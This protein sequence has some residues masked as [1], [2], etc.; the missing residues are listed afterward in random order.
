MRKSQHFKS[1]LNRIIL[2]V[3]LTF[4]FFLLYAQ[5]NPT[6]WL[7]PIPKQ[8]GFSPSF[9]YYV[10]KD[11]KGFVWISSYE[12]LNRYDGHQ[13]KLYRAVKEDVH[14]LRNNN[15]YGH[16]FEDSKSNIWFSTSK[17]IHRY[18]RK[19]DSFD[20]FFL[21]HDST[22]TL[23]TD[24]H[25]FAF[26]NDRMLWVQT[27]SG[28][29]KYD[30]HTQVDTL[31][32]DSTL[33]YVRPAYNPQGQVTKI[34]S[35]G[36]NK[37]LLEID[38]RDQNI[39]Q[40]SN[41]LFTN[42]EISEIYYQNDSLVF[43][44]SSENGIQR[45]NPKTDQRVSIGNFT[46]GR[47]S[48]CALDDDHILMAIQKY[49]LFRYHFKDDY[50]EKINTRFISG[51]GE[52]ING[53]WK[54]YKDSDENI[55]VSDE[56]S[57][58]TVGNLKKNKFCSIPKF[59]STTANSNFSYRKMLEDS[60]GKIWIA[61]QGAGLF[62][63]DPESGETQNFSYEKNMT[64]AIPSNMVLD[65]CEDA[66]GKIWVATKEGIAYFLGGKRFRKVPV[67]TTSAQ[68]IPY[69]LSFLKIDEQ[70]ILAS[71]KDGI[72]H[73]IKKG[74]NYQLKKLYA[75]DTDGNQLYQDKK[76]NII[77]ACLNADL[78][79]FKWRKE[80]LNF[81]YQVPFNTHVNAFWENQFDEVLWCAT[82]DGLFKISHSDQKYQKPEYIAFQ[83]QSKVYSIKSILANEPHS[84]WMGTN[85]GLL[86]VKKDSFTVESFSMADG[87]QSLEFNDES[88]L[89]RENGELW[90]GGFNGI[91][92]VPN[93]KITRTNF[94]PQLKITDIK[95]NDSPVEDLVCSEA[96]A[97]NITE[98][99]HLQRSFG[100]NTI[101]LSFVGMDYSDPKST[102]LEFQLTGSDKNPVRLAKG[103]LG[104]VR[105]SNLPPDTYTFNLSAANSDGVWGKPQKILNIT[106]LPP[107]TQTYLFY[108]L[109]LTTIG[110]AT[111]L[112]YRRR[113]AQ[114]RKEESMN[115]RIIENQMAALRSQM[116]PHFIYNSMQTVNGIIARNDNMEAMKYVNKFSKLM[117]MILENS[118]KGEITL[119]EEYGYPQN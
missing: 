3:K 54:L 7:R 12:G 42:V 51:N 104:F 55:W 20:Q 36:K 46:K 57:G 96:K 10:F 75:T 5:E 44:C 66:D 105:Y 83:N 60:Q 63:Y 109:V 65:L 38:V 114:I 56:N 29:F 89:L 84:F 11:S 76:G 88:A 6:V 108:A 91:T 32:I 64:E 70:N 30:T 61:S 112:Y 77:L 39:Y 71:A 100:D 106:I 87:V 26:E 79:V 4:S 19:Y 117:R 31:I 47:A 49:G 90:F 78:K 24:Y 41:K 86:R 101:S 16:F 28:I 103:D 9:N 95:I 58:V 45:W 69:F 116:N 62:R 48:F 111:Y 2:A 8:I 34:F 22:N 40:K 1:V 68:T 80:A 33:F 82:A 43:I 50:L 107:F 110:I 15:V 74:A 67:A 23:H 25:T 72:Y 52:M 21:S 98:I 115:T 93:K 81:Q 119:E 102:Q 17:A 94:S 14:T 59:E 92:I 27:N 73:V 85:R 53:F 99:K 37:G 35:F 118:R 13:V 113:I 18:N 97:T